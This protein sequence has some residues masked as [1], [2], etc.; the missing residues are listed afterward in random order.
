MR[1]YVGRQL[2]RAGTLCHRLR[3][4]AAAE[5]GYRLATR[6]H[7]EPAW[8]IRLGKI[9]EARDH[10][11]AAEAAY[12]RTLEVAKGGSQQATAHYR[13]ARARVRRKDWDDAEASFAAAVSLRPERSVWHVHRAENQ[14]RRGDWPAAAASYQE[15]LRLDPEQSEW[16]ARLVRGHLKTGRPDLAVEAAGGS[17]PTSRR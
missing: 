7:P 10:W 17:L 16:R 13:Q 8:Y 4:L 9:Q 5:L 2:T 12:A 3:L 15:A 14:E 11:A 1:R 6:L